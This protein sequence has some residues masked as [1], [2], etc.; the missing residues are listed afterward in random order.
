MI[1]ELIIPSERIVSKIFIIRNRKV[2]LDR[3]LAELY[4]VKT[5]ILN[6]AVKRNIKRFPP[7]FMFRLDKDEFENL[8]SQIV[9]SRWVGRRYLPKRT[10]WCQIGTSSECSRSQFATLKRDLNLKSHF[11]ISSWCSRH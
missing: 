6:Q 8:K 5:K 9:T 1:K 4:G 3:D 10:N 7:D 2:M 11:A